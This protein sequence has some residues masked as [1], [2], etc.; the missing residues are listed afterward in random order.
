MDCTNGASGLGSSK[1]SPMRGLP[2]MASSSRP[3]RSR[4]HNKP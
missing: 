4:K 1:T 2:K 3:P